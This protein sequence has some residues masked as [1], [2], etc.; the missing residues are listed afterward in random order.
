MAPK[1]PELAAASKAPA[2]QTTAPAQTS[3][4]AKA[5]SSAGHDAASPK[6]SVAKRRKFTSSPAGAVQMVEYTP[7][8]AIAAD[9][10]SIN[11]QGRVS[12]IALRNNP[13]QQTCPL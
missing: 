10:K 4:P 1:V 11:V 2:A 8:N 9:N 7:L 5:S 12:F 6:A 13:L 3:P